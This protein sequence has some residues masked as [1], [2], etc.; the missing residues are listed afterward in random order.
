MLYAVL[1]P[2][3]MDQEMTYLDQIV[4]YVSVFVGLQ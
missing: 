4:L 1:S 2:S 3:S